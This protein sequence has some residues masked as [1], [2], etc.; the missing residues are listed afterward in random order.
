MTAAA[1]DFA[2]AKAIVGSAPH[3]SA[4]NDAFASALNDAINAFINA[5]NDPAGAAQQLLNKANDLLKP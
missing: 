1:R 2:A 4:T 5:P 3:G